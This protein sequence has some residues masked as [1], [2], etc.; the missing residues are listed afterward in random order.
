MANNE[1]LKQI[2]PIQKE[3]EPVKKFKISPRFLLI[4]L[5]VLV[6][7]GIGIVAWLIINPSQRDI[8]N[9][10]ETITN[11]IT[12]E[13]LILILDT[14]KKNTQNYCNAIIDEDSA[15]CELIEAEILKNSCLTLTTFIFDIFENKNKDSCSKIIELTFEECSN[16]IDSINMQDINNCNN[17][18]CEFAFNLYLAI[19]QEDINLCDN[20]ND[21]ST[22]NYCKLY[23]NKD[24]GYCDYSYCEDIYYSNLR[25]ITDDLSYCEKIINPEGKKSCLEY[26]KT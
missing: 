26:K 18:V 25:E 23:L 6:V 3:I 16:I 4:L 9:E 10:E 2:E 21:K 17:Q 12:E 20:I 13:D 22:Q 5:L 24:M 14:C 11:G 15:K 7:I 8:S 19:S 1:D